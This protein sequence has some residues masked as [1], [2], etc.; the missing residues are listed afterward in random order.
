MLV[1]DEYEYAQ[2]KQHSIKEEYNFSN[3]E[4]EDQV[5]LF[6]CAEISPD[7]ITQQQKQV[8]PNY[9]IRNE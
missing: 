9:P 6:K 2:V 3:N 7:Y 5:T 4:I 1:F 8:F